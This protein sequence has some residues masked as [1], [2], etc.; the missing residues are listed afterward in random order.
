MY[1]NTINYAKKGWKM[2]CPM[3]VDTEHDPM[4]SLLA[5]WLLF[6]NTPVKDILAGLSYHHMVTSI[7]PF[8][9][10]KK[11]ILSFGPLVIIVSTIA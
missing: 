9:Y 11:S 3:L 10:Q 6:L 4:L 1:L 5:F 8:V 2:F 7:L